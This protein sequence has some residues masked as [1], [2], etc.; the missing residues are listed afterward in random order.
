MLLRF[1]M[2]GCGSPVVAQ[3]AP[4]ARIWYR[5]RYL[6]KAG[7]D[8]ALAKASLTDRQVMVERYLQVRH[9]RH[10]R[11]AS[12]EFKYPRTLRALLTRLRFSHIPAVFLSLCILGYL[13]IISLSPQARAVLAPDAGNPAAVAAATPEAVAEAER[14]CVKLINEA[15]EE[16][17]GTA[18]LAS[19]AVS[20]AHPPFAHCRTVV[21]NPTNP[22]S[23][24]TAQ[25]P[26]RTVALSPTQPTLGLRSPL[27]HPCTW[28][29]SCNYHPLVSFPLPRW[30]RRRRASAWA[31]SL[32]CWWS[33]STGRGS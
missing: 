33:T 31:T 19:D 32:R 13:L 24:L 15:P 2:R 8:H 4:I 1:A 12:R 9:R 20:H 25:P 27:S 10:W 28:S 3:L 23:A 14:A 5:R 6:D 17:R 29:H 21:T 22:W 26:L 30:P 18:G 16:A 11:Q 7:P